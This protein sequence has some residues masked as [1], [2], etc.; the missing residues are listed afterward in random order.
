MK[1]KTL[2][3][4]NR[5]IGNTVRR[6]RKEK[7]WT[8]EELAKNCEFSSVYVAQIETAIR[9]ASVSSVLILAKTFGLNCGDFFVQ[10]E[11]ERQRLIKEE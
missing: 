7:G 11:T 3:M 2:P 9:G 10:I 1:T 5:A 4:V 8:Q 6:L